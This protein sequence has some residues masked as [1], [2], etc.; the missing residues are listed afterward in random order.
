MVS[1]TPQIGQRG[2]VRLD[3]FLNRPRQQAELIAFRVGKHDPA[4]IG[5]LADVNASCPRL[6]HP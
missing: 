5:R 6:Q 3:N 4:R 1:K 2:S